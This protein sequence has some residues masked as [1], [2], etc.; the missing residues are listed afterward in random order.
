M[1]TVQSPL[2][3]YVV[4]HPA[5]P[6][7]RELAGHLHDWFRLKQDE[8]EGTEAGLPVWFRAHLEAG[9]IAPAV[10]WGEAAL[11]VLVV[12][13][14]DHMVV[15][16]AWRSA[17]QALVEAAEA[18]PQDCLVLLAT[19][20]WSAFRLGYLF[21]ARNRI[22][23]GEPR[24]E[25]TPEV[26][27]ADDRDGMERRRLRIAARARVLRRAV[28][29]AV[30]RELRKEAGQQAP[31]PIDVFLSHAKRDGAELA[32]ALRDGMA[33]FGQLKPWYDANELPPGY[34]W[35][36][37][38]EE[39]A[40][41]NTAALV[42]IVTDTYPTRYWCRREVNLA[43]TPRQLVATLDGAVTAWTVQPT[44][45]LSRHGA[46]WSR[47]LAQLAQVP[48][49]GWE[50]DQDK[51]RARVE[52]IV[53]RLLLE[54]LLVEY[55]RRYARALMATGSPDP[56]RQLA[57][58]TWV[59]D[60]WS[61]MQ[62]L[63][64]LQPVAGARELVLA[65]PGHGLRTAERRELHDL[66][67]LTGRQLGLPVRM[68]TQ[69]RLGEVELPA[70]PDHLLI[71]LSAG[72]EAADLEPAGV[73]P[74]HVDDL[75]VR[76]T[77]RLLE[78]DNRVV[79]GGTL[80]EYAT[81]LTRALID[82]A[83]GWDRD[84]DARGEEA[85]GDA[86]DLLATPLVNYS[87]WPAYSKITPR[88][89]AD[90]TGVCEFLAV[91]PP[92]GAPVPADQADLKDPAHA[93]AAADALTRM[94]DTSTAATSTRVVVAGKRRN[95]LGWLPG[96]AEEVACSVQHGQLVLV[97]G[98]FGGC[99]SDIAAYLRDPAA[100][101]PPSLTLAAAEGDARFQ[102]LLR[103][104]GAR[105]HA[106]AR[107]QWLEQQLAAW[108]GVLHGRAPWPFAGVDRQAVLALLACGSPSAAIARVLRILAG[109][110]AR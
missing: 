28:T 39:A 5:S 110:A 97:I 51:V 19:V 89:R 69:E 78:R 30:T 80:G 54:A 55:Y 52:D 43:R 40:R 105:E 109:L 45:A 4:Y 60:P 96:I 49:V 58:M 99:A 3:I 20:D 48:H 41:R 11:N 87:G 94:R 85:P 64:Q 10:A 46:G 6:E 29:E 65:Y 72:G 101:L 44:I 8:G 93:R 79:Y 53:D 88:I 61:L 104:E 57:L 75:L 14:D 84:A 25:T 98:G 16:A 31:T 18:A 2:S 108:R 9:A 50:P 81:D 76:L 62:L 24:V 27:D 102:L 74:K 92:G 100:P 33:D 73:G 37:P 83:L 36:Q 21:G 23:A 71:A 26:R 68:V 106:A 63:G 90:L 82:T 12:L 17:L 35:K 56:G 13:I 47:P 32:V 67:A 42:S 86:A 59:P 34:H 70:A 1:Q 95:W 66:V 107:F 7:C 103:T 22:P 38:M 91:D 15:D 77:R